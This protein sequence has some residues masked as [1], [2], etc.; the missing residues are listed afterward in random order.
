VKVYFAAPLF[1]TGERM[2]NAGLA[3][4]PREAGHEVFLPQEQETSAD[5]PDRN[6]RND[7]A[8]LDWSD[9]VIGVADGPDPD[10][11]TAWEIG[12]AFATQHP[13]ILLRTDFRGANDTGA[14]YNLM[15]AQSASMRIDLSIPSVKQAAEAVLEALAKLEDRKPPRR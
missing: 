7:L 2:F 8:H 15:L 9:T 5:A 1:T 13:I 6:F 12:Y 11:G 10:S 14:P 4:R 3:A